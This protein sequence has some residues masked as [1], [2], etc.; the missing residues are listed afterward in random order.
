MIESRPSAIMSEAKAWRRSY[1]FTL[2]ALRTDP[3]PQAGAKPEGV[4]TPISK[5]AI[6]R[7]RL[8]ATFKRG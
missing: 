8:V 3:L 6:A 7:G 4:R 1:V 5:S 2:Y